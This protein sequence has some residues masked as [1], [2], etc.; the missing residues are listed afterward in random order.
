MI[1]LLSIHPIGQLAAILVGFYAA[2]YGY[3]RIQSLHFNKVVKFPRKRHAA[4][5]AIAL[6]FML[7]GSAAG[8]FL[9]NTYLP[10]TKLEIHNKIGMIIVTLG[11]LGIITG[12]FL[13]ASPRKRKVLPVIH[14]V[15][16]F[17][18]LLL[19]F[20][21]IVTEPSHIFA[22]CCTGDVNDRWNCL[23]DGKRDVS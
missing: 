17:A 22:M 11:V 18:I 3:Q 19:A 20:V 2:Y 12:Y 15:C 10:G 1:F 21:Q 16:N 13:Y 4:A 8:S 7:M 6:I 9:K 14:G 23:Y 5:G